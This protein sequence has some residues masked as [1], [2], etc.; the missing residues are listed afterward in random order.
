[1]LTEEQAGTIE[2]IDEN[3]MIVALA[4]SG[5][6][7]TFISLVER[8]LQQKPNSTI[9]M[10]TF[11]NAATSEMEERVKKRVGAMSSRVYVGTFAR[12]MR[13]QFAPLTNKRRLLIGGEYYGFVK[14]AMSSQCVDFDEL[15]ECM[16]AIDRL[17]RDL[18]FVDDGS[19][20]SRVFVE[21][22]TL[23]KR[24]GRY[25]LNLMARELIKGLIEGLVKP[26][27]QD[28]ILVDEFQDTDALQYAWLKE[29]SRS[30]TVAVVGDDD[31]SIYA[32]RGGRG[33][34]AFVDFQEDF[35]A[36]AYLLSN[37]FRCAPEVL[38]KAKSFIEN[39]KDR[40][41]KNMESPKPPG[42][43]VS[44]R[45]I[46]AGYISEFTKT[47]SERDDIDVAGSRKNESTQLESYRYIA[48][49]L[50]GKET[51]G[52]SVLA[53][54][55]LQLDELEQ[56]MSELDINVVRVGGKS[57]FDNEHAFGISALLLGVVSAKGNNQLST[58]LGWLGE[59][60]DVLHQIFTS[61]KG[62]GFTAVS[63]GGD[64]SWLPITIAMQEFAIEAQRVSGKD[65]IQ[66]FI[67]SFKKRIA[68]HI[69]KRGDSDEQF[70][71]AILDL[72]TRILISGKGSLEDRA[73][74][75]ASKL[76]K[77][78][79]KPNHRQSNAVVLTTL[80]SSKGLEWP[81]VW[82]LGLNQ[83]NIPLLKGDDSI[84]RVEEERR[85]L[86][87]GMTRAE[88]NL[89][90]SYNEKT[91]SAFIEEITGFEP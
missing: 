70:Q 29:N 63:V 18:A 60:E 28:F 11:T 14:R 87:V 65:N 53:R 71:Y 79:I 85:L 52:W 27:K 51:G 69:K 43:S 21:Y 56:A 61:S 26:I 36:Q 38:D 73:F 32:W 47:K 86:Y 42:G 64:A 3:K 55:N 58:G 17:G 77:P 66:Q 2:D 75:L 1:M 16:S 37:C 10:V 13:G 24:Y 83:N 9:A 57:I 23:L 46:P 67:K 22:T 59:S 82:I 25:D 20:Y 91:P 6:T 78:N 41:H 89:V 7:H 54:T 72:F 8:I 39:N 45:E 19:S 90:L 5:K 33:Y 35:D 50:K 34:D 31:Q 62:M 30:K 84:E 40:I 81:N 48:N 44:I 15:S 76:Q 80:N 68:A 74:R 49:E 12:L 88:D 4:G